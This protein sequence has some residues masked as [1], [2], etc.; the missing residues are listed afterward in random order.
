MGLG[1]SKK[2]SFETALANNDAKAGDFGW[3]GVNLIN[4]KTGKAIEGARYAL[5][6][7]FI[8]KN[9]EGLKLKI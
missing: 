3:L 9:T 2:E 5:A 4:Q 8:L 6:M 1:I 7:I